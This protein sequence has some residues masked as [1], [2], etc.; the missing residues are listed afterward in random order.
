MTMDE[1]V[2]GLRASL[3]AA[4]DLLRTHGEEPVSERLVHYER[5]LAMGDFDAVQSL[6]AEVTGTMGSLRDVYLYPSD[7]SQRIALNARLEALVAQIRE[8]SLAAGLLLRI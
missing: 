1:A 3:E 8:Q 4:I 5:R 7:D 6:L 2:I